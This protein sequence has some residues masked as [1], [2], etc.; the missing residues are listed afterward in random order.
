MF[1][2]RMLKNNTHETH[3]IA[4]LTDFPL[5][6]FFI[7]IELQLAKMIVLDNSSISY[8]IC[9]KK[10]QRFAY[11]PHRWCVWTLCLKLNIGINAIA[12]VHDIHSKLCLYFDLLSFENQ[13][14][15]TAQQNHWRLIDL[16]CINC[17]TLKKP[18]EWTNNSAACTIAHMCSQ[19]WCEWWIFFLIN[20]F[21]VDCINCLS[22]YFYHVN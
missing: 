12:R 18:I 1:H 17:I 19:C 7:C 14:E 6:R 8:A 3:T 13:M 2:L 10:L 16:H 9:T 5:F 11:H 20:Q 4:Q 21:S 22:P 15:N